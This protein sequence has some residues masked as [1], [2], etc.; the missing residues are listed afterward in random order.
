[1][2]KLFVFLFVAFCALGLSAQDY[3]WIEKAP[4]KYNSATTQVIITRTSPCNQG[5]EAFMDFIPR[6]RTDK[7][8]RKSRGMFTPDDEMAQTIFDNFDNWSI[9]KAG[10]GVNKKEGYRYYGTWFSV[11]ENMV[12]FQREELPASPDQDLWGGSGSYFR[13]QRVNGKWY[14]TGIV[15]AG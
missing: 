8:F 7:A 13:F 5:Q 14:L 15:M 2:K 12:C 4:G 9:I 6:F 1:M 11:S 3:S 10:K